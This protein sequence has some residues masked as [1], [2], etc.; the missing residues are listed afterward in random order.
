MSEKEIDT[1][2]EQYIPLLKDVI[3]PDKVQHSFHK[4]PIINQKRRDAEES[5]ATTR[6]AITAQLKQELNPLIL[7]AINSAIEQVTVE[8]KQILL[9]E[10]RGSLQHRLST[11]IEEALDKQR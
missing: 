2:D 10:L 7:A 4:A 6:E 3:D 1:R 11:L 9:D 8:M 5:I